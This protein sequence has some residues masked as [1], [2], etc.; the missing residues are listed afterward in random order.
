MILYFT[1][2][3]VKEEF[4]KLGLDF[5]IKYYAGDKIQERLKR[6][7]D[8]FDDSNDLSSACREQPQWL[9][10]LGSENVS[11]GSGHNVLMVETS[12]RGRLTG[13][14]A[15]AVESAA[16]RDFSRS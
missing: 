16:R 12:G 11:L 5:F 4:P 2:F 15:C 14:Q 10:V 8:V 13:R 9:P 3:A 7:K 1:C 6:T